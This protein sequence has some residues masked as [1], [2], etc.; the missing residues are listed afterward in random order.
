MVVG[1][2]GE[3]VGASWRAWCGPGGGEGAGRGD[4]DIVSVKA[5]PGVVFEKGGKGKGGAGGLGAGKEG[6]GEGEEVEKT[7]LQK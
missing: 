5:A 6:E 2:G 4:F 3:V 1:G 7:M